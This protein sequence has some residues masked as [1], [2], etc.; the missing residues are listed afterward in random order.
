MHLQG[1]QSTPSV[2]AETLHTGR[3]ET[4]DINFESSYWK[5]LH[6]YYTYILN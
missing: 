4:P 2:H 3:D 1:T 6:A 5:L